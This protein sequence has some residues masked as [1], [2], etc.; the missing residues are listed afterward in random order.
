[1]PRLD[2]KSKDLLKILPILLDNAET[3]AFL[4]VLRVLGLKIL[5]PK[6]ELFT[7]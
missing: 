2:G 5:S 7:D 3:I 4:T 6:Q 1:M